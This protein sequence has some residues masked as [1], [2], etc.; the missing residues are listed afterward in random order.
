[1]LPGVNTVI[2]FN[3]FYQN[4]ANT[5]KKLKTNL[6]EKSSWDLFEQCFILQ[7]SDKIHTW[8]GGDYVH[9]DICAWKSSLGLFIPLW[10]QQASKIQTPRINTKL[11]KSASVAGGNAPNSEWNLGIIVLQLC[12]D[13][14]VQW[15]TVMKHAIFYLC[16]HSVFYILNAEVGIPVLD[17]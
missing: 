3:S 7:F 15:K 6:W 17:L 10:K 9:V 11:K 16:K 8:E 1:M 4:C 13:V 12:F 2:N 14:N 5:N